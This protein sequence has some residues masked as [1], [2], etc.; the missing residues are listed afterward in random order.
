MSLVA[1]LRLVHLQIALPVFVL[2]EARSRNQG[3]I[4]DLSLPHRH[5]TCAE[6][7]FESLKDLLAR[8]VLLQSCRKVRIV[9]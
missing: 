1:H 7:G 5:P 3:V 9:I 2:G 6:A 8:I 4:H